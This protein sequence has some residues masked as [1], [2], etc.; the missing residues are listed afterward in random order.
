MAC[1]V[2]QELGEWVEG[3]LSVVYKLT[4]TEMVLFHHTFV[5]LKARCPWTVACSPDDFVLGGERKLFQEYY[6][7]LVSV[8]NIATGLMPI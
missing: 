6:S 8:H 2:L 1:N 4:F 5:A 3:T 7:P